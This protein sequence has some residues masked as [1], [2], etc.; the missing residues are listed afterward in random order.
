MTTKISGQQ[1][2]RAVTALSVFLTLV[3]ATSLAAPFDF[4]DDAGDITEIHVPLSLDQQASYVWT[5]T[6][7]EAQ[8]RGPCRP[9]YWA[10][11]TL[12]SGLYGSHVVGW[13]LTR[14]VFLLLS[15]GLMLW[16]FAGE[17]QL[18][19]WPATAATAI[20]LVMPM[21]SGLWYRICFSE[22][23]AMPLVL[24][25]LI[26]AC[27]AVR[28]RHPWT[29]DLMGALAVLGAIATKNVFMAVVPAQMLLRAWEPGLEMRQALRKHARSAL[30]LAAVLVVPFTHAW[31]FAQSEVSANEYHVSTPS[32]QTLWSMVRAVA[33]G[34][35]YDFL[36]PG[37]VITGVVVVRY[38]NRSIWLEHRRAWLSGLLLLAAGI[39]VYLPVLGTRSPAGRYTVPA[40]WGT[41]LLIACLLT[42][43]W[44]STSRR[45]VRVATTVL[46]L[47]LLAMVGVNVLR[48][49]EL[50]NRSRVLWQTTYWIAQ[51]AP[52]NARIVIMD[53]V[54]GRGELIHLSNA[55]RALGRPDVTLDVG[56]DAAGADAIVANSKTAPPLPRSFRQAALFAP[57]SWPH[58]YRWL[59][60]RHSRRRS[61]AIVIWNKRDRSSFPAR[62]TRSMPRIR[63][64]PFIGPRV[65]YRR[66]GIGA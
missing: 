56:T 20:G 33:L 7:G 10:Y 2:R 49:Q 23:W 66:P 1:W 11:L 4:E 38:G 55:I 5:R 39:V 50:A 60:S 51:Q 41:D 58:A 30:L 27:R 63:P 21:R 65:A 52:P 36:G 28:S 16:L 59:P 25:A 19:L 37:L 31:L 48:Q 22:A 17:L 57:P 46:V 62:S 43:L 14:L 6:A 9:L 8:Q 44:T 13:R 34:S 12:N 53:G 64:V 24:I 40:C 45:G 32:L 54:C 3:Y 26:S 47:G 29:W 18:P 42:A 61:A 35:G 15:A